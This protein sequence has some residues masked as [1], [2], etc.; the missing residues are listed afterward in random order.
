MS[1]EIKAEFIGFQYPDIKKW[2]RIVDDTHFRTTSEIKRDMIASGNIGAGEK[3]LFD[4]D[5]EVKITPDNIISDVE[6]A[7]RN[8]RLDKADV[9]V[10]R[11]HF[12][13]LSLESQKES[14]EKAVLD[15]AEK[16]SKNRT[17]KIDEMLDVNQS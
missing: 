6:L 5:S 17:A 1:K 12:D 13:N 14:V 15:K 16:A 8:G 9:Q 10:L 11:D 2:P 3:G 4:Y 7:L